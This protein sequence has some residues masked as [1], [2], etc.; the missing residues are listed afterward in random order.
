MNPIAILYVEDEE[1]DVM[2]LQHVLT[3][4]GIRNPLQTVK[5]GKAAKDYLAG[6]AP[7]ADRGQ[8]P[9]PGL[10]L[11]DLNLPYWSG[12]E[13]L[14][15][16]RQQPQLRRL[17]VVVFTSSSRPDDIARAYDAGANAYVVKPN[18]LADLPSLALA[19]RDFWL[20]H[21]RLP[22]HPGVQPTSPSIG[23]NPAGDHEPGNRK[24]SAGRRQPLGRRLAAGVPVLQPEAGG[25][26][27]TLPES[28]AE[29]A[30]HLQKQSFDVL[31]LDLSLPDSTG[32]DTFVRAR[33]AAPHLPIV[34]LT[35]VADEAVGLEAVRHG[36]Q[37]Y[38]IKGQAY[39]RQ[40]ARA[41]RYAIERKQAE[42]ALKAG[43]SQLAAR[44]R[45]TGSAR[46]GTDRRAVGSQPGLAGRNGPAPARRGGAPAGAAPAGRGGGDR[47][48]AGL[49]RASRPA[50]PG[51][52]GAQAGPATRGQATA[53]PAG[54]A[55][56]ASASWKD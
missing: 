18:A 42:T 24:H 45:S 48:G 1:T 9:L 17:P 15:W 32:R 30:A 16:I 41:I 38:L 19:L 6:N 53:L 37:D 21:N 31:L 39:G 13:V 40:T 46:A 7:F 55:G 47:A 8:H 51:P 44:A 52:D 33:A 25:F 14:E 27:F 10:V 54:G 23:L 49:A 22:D 56:R 3:K 29:A 43:G 4:A 5:D 28:W 20:I 36:I 34:V 26:R 12:F 2:L 50:G 35:G 11:L